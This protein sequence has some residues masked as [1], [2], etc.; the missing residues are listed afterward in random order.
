MKQ[1]ENIHII[2]ASWTEAAAN[3]KKALEMACAVSLS[4]CESERKTANIMK[5]EL[6]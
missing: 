1:V 2:E 3:L 6:T 4:T 5:N